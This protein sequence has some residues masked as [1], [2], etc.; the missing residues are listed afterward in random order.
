MYA[1]MRFYRPTYINTY[2]GTLLYQKR[3]TTVT[4]AS[5]ADDFYTKGIKT[6]TVIAFFQMMYL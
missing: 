2:I 1:C 4:P 5:E 3:T 6:D